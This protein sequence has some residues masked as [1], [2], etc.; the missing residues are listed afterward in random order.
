MLKRIL[1]KIPK[2]KATIALAIFVLSTMQVQVQFAVSFAPFLQILAN[3]FQTLW[4]MRHA[5]GIN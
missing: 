3:L 1:R 2:G 4:M 5:P